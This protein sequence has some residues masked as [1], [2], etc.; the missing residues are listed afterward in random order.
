MTHILHKCPHC[1]KDAHIP[2]TGALITL[3]CN[4]CNKDLGEI[5]NKED[6]FDYCPVCTCRQFYLTRDFNQVLGCSIMLIA[7]IL[8]PKTYGLSLPVLA[9]IDWLLHR[10]SKGIVNCYRCG[11]E[12]H[13]F[14]TAKRFKT[15][16]HHIGLK[17]DKYR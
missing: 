4:H 11:C 9:G 12:F 7:I 10:R 16:M 17:Y 3:K 13:G 1:K 14:D 6:V 15:F 2:Y 8:V 5:K